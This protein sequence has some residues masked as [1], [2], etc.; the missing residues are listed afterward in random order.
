MT[1][2]NHNIDNQFVRIYD[3][4]AKKTPLYAKKYEKDVIKAMCDFGKGT[5]EVSDAKGKI[6]GA[7]YETLIIALFI[8]LY[9]KKK[10]DFTP[11]EDTKDCGQP[12]QY[13]GNL[14]SKKLRHAYPRLRE[15][16]FIALVSRTPEIDW[17]ELDKGNL[18]INEVVSMLMDTMEA[19]IN[20][21]L[22]VLAEKLKE[23]ESYFYNKNS[24][25]D[26]FMQLT[27]PDIEKITDTDAAES[28]D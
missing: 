23:D 18:T 26:I 27:N 24:F 11:Y 2:D 3:V 21:G 28:L 8:G 10:A 5:T 7:A 16:I 15:Y 12:I 9:S 4:W 13:W 22:S 17:I 6:L 1:L 14:D 25:L 20:Y 19:Y